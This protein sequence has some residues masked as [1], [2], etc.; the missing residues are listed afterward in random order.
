MY[1]AN[2]RCEKSESMRKGQAI[3]MASAS[4]HGSGSLAQMAMGNRGQESLDFSRRIG[5]PPVAQT[6][7]DQTYG[8][9]RAEIQDGT[10]LPGTKL[11]TTALKDRLGVSLSTLREAL[12]RLAGDSYVTWEGQ[13]GFRVSPI[14]IPDLH[15]LLA[16]RKLI[17]GEALEQSILN[18]D[19]A[20]EGRVLGAFHELQKVEA[21]LKAVIANGNES[22]TFD[23]GAIWEIKNDQFHM[24]LISACNS[25][26]LHRS[27]RELY[28]QTSRYRR[29]AFLKRGG[30]MRPV[31]EE[32][33]AIFDAAMSRNV[34]WLRQAAS[35]HMD[36]IL[37]QLKKY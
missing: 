16:M 34:N 32:H 21:R 19:D 4:A 15:D 17:E 20:W 30:H 27:F 33:K 6:L 5:A 23:L 11:A 7:S 10:L 9:L 35:R 12:A 29:V 25:P 8:R 26:R 1:A 36:G 28:S 31:D 18:G 24:T 22:E 13:K 37:D 14:S 3:H 2:V